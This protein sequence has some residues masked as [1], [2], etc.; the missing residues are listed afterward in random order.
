MSTS[1]K[2]G[3]GLLTLTLAL[4][5]PGL[6]V[7]EIY[8]YVDSNGVIR[9]TDKPP[10]RDA[11]PVELPKVQ[12]YTSE[13]VLD[14]DAPAPE[15]DSVLA[16]DG[17]AYDSVELLAPAADQVFNT[18]SGSVTAAASVSPGLRP[19]HSLIFLVDGQATA[20]PPGESRTELT[21]LERGTHSL[22]AVVQDET[23]ALRAQS[24]A[25]QFHLHQPSTLQRSFD[26]TPGSPPIPIDQQPRP[27]KDKD[28]QSD[29]RPP[30]APG[31]LTRPPIVPPPK[32]PP[33]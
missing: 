29:P 5:T 25:I 27:D 17:D 15:P 31:Q 23:G 22:Q 1:A 19:G 33:P 9:Y 26:P 13:S 21:G 20:A 32:K 10:S 3:C 16:A 30:R 18:G 6:A 8:K 11:Q 12:T 14:E 2:I 24:P 28:G 7:A 4:A